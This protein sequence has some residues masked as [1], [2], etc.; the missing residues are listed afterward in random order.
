M[1]NKNQFQF[2]F[3]PKLDFYRSDVSKY[4]YPKYPSGPYFRFTL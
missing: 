2:Y 3:D 4:I 1:S